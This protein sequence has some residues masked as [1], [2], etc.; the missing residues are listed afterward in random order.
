MSKSYQIRRFAI[1]IVTG[2]TV[3]LASCK[4]NRDDSLRPSLNIPQVYDSVGY[5]FNTESMKP[6]I[7]QY[8]TLVSEA[9]KGNQNGQYVSEESLNSAFTKGI[10]SLQ[11]VTTPYFASRLQAQNN[12][13]FAE[14]SKASGGSF[15][16]F[17][18]SWEGGVYKSY[19]LDEYGLEMGQMIEKGLLGATLYNYAM[20]LT[21]GTFTTATVDQMLF[22][23]GG[24][25]RFLN[26]DNSAFYPNPDRFMAGYA[27][28]RDDGTGTGLYSQNRQAFIT[29]QTAVQKGEDYDSYRDEAL[30]AIKL[31]WEKINAATVINNIHA[32]Y[33][34]LQAGQL[35]DN[36]RAD[37]LHLIS[38]AAGF[39][40]GW[41]TVETQNKKITDAQIDE[42]LTLLNAPYDRS[43]AVYRFVTNTDTEATK[44]T[45]AV[46]KLQGVYGFTNAEVESFR[47]NYV[48][49]QA[50]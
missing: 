32:S 33:T 21:N 47:H 6:L 43:A 19:L 24:N 31:N 9:R 10:F 11:S 5:A 27:A 22:L 28:R 35:D 26:S 13:F 49:D 44:L 30:A 7:Q 50:R 4:E 48:A 34:M 41:R 46:A 2:F 23:Y 25:P 18:R 8:M 15:Y 17:D 39:L 36:K 16:P 14:L 1:L 40:H 29:L 38:E 12:G 3:I 42:V 45:D 37:I 20:S